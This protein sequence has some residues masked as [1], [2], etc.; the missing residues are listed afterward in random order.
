[1]PESANESANQI[2]RDRLEQAIEIATQALDHNEMA[3]AL[4]A[5]L[6]VD[7]EEAETEREWIVEQRKKLVALRG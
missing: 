3:L 5:D 1:M 6:A 2:T 4:A 7:A